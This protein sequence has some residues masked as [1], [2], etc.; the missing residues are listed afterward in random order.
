[1]KVAGLSARH[2][3]IEL[4][5]SREQ[6][7]DLLRKINQPRPPSRDDILGM[8]EFVAKILQFLQE[9]FSIALRR[10]AKRRHKLR[11]LQYYRPL[12]RKLQAIGQV[13]RFVSSLPVLE[14]GP[15]PVP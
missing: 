8:G 15:L 1:M 10:K 13:S 5:G 11:G 4:L 9:H 6:T 14:D 7:F 2:L 12:V 3:G